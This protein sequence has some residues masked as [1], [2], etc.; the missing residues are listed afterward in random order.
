MLYFPLVVR[1]FP[2]WFHA[3]FIKLA[4]IAIKQT[5]DQ[6][7][8]QKPQ[9]IIADIVSLQIL[10]AALCFKCYLQIFDIVIAV[11]FL[12]P[13]YVQ[14]FTWQSLLCFLGLF[15]F[16]L[17]KVVLLYLWILNP[18]KVFKLFPYI[19]SIAN[20]FCSSGRCQGKLQ[21]KLVDGSIC[22]L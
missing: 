3:H 6:P 19:F 14:P 11:M 7:T 18:L 16:L 15:G 10:L 9:F 8:K 2:P 4:C 17:Y 20:F 21:G 22:S 5:K 12:I 13:L 1:C